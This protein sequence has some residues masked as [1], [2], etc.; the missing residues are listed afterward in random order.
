MSKKA[1]LTTFG[2]IFVVLFILGAVITSLDERLNLLSMGSA[3][4]VIK[5]MDSLKSNEL[6]SKINAL[7]EYK[8]YLQGEIIGLKLRMDNYNPT[9]IVLS[10]VFKGYVKL[11][12]NAGY[13]LIACEDAQPYLDGYKVILKI[14]NPASV[15]YNGFTLEIEWGKEYIYDEKD[16]FGLLSIRKYEEWKKSLRKETKSFTNQLLP[17]R[18]NKVELILTPAKPEEIKYIGLSM[19]T[20]TVALY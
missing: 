13:F 4:T 2:V 10:P 17:G 5:P 6:L 11:D 7:E 12:T 20:D 15:T 16:P 19:N 3:K 1:L 18:W 14:G 9:S 8:E